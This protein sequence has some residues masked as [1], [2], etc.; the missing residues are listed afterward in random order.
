MKQSARKSPK[1]TAVKKKALGSKKN[2]KKS[3]AP[4]KSARKPSV[5]TSVS[6]KSA[7]RGKAKGASKEAVSQ[8]K[9]ESTRKKN[10]MSSSVKKPSKTA[11][12]KVKAESKTRSAAKKNIKNE[13]AKVDGRKSVTASPRQ[14]TGR[15][16]ISEKK[17]LTHEE[18][19]EIKLGKREKL[20]E[21]AAKE[22]TNTSSL[23][24]QM[25]ASPTA[26]MLKPFR[27]AAKKNK[28]VAKTKLKSKSKSAF[29]AKPP[30]GS[31]KYTL[32]LRVHSPISE[33]YFSTGGVDPAAAMVRLAKSKGLDMIAITDYHSGDFVDLVKNEARETSVTVLPGIDLRCSVGNCSEVSLV[34]LFPEE[35]TSESLNAVLQELGIPEVAKGRKT[36]TLREE[37]KKIIEI[38][39][40]KG[41]VLIP[42]RLDKT[43]HRV[44][45]VKELVEEY[46]FHA[47]DL[48]HPDNPEYFK[49][50][51]PS[52]EF[53]FLSSSNAN[54]LG[55]IGS[56]GMQLKLSSPGFMGLKSLVSRR[57]TRKSATK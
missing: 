50:H 37:M 40:S 28:E 16:G 9:K 54:A 32:D 27:D 47:F 53:T 15:K 5:N 43:P 48:V 36:F 51:W 49:E 10:T 20:K 18:K 11:P 57:E 7:T 29:I 13:P 34:A 25:I 52:G 38:V 23:T 41:G 2:T 3:A 33:G 8:K 1:N 4:E 24:P 39:E 31:K 21:I 14:S 30:K 12:G 26:Q 44:I 42:T 35:F 46:G 56:R 17:Q 6:S 19:E 22:D 45:A 55:Q